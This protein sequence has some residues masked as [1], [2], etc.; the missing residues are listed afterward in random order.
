MTASSQKDGV[1]SRARFSVPATVSKIASEQLGA[2][3]KML[4]SLPAQNSPTN[5]KEWQERQSLVEAI[6]RPRAASTAEQL[7]VSLDE[8]SI[9]GVNILRISPATKDTAGR[10][11]IFL[12]GGGYVLF[13]AHSNL[14]IPALIA[15]ATGCEV[16]SVDYTLAP[17][18]NWQ[19]ITDQILSVWEG[20]VES[21]IKP[22]A[23]GLFGDSAGGALAAG[24]V[25]KMRDRGLQL[26]GALYLVS[27]WSDITVNGDTIQTLESS[28]P[29]LKPEELLACANVYADPA[30]QHHPYVSP[31]NGDYSKP[32]PPTLIQAGTREIFL[33]H[34]VRHY[35]AI[36][37]GGNKCLLDIYEGMPHAFPAIVPFAPEA[38]TAINRAARFLLEE[39]S[40]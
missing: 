25:L 12:H 13:S 4:E 35:N 31:I 8:D 39:L 33:S 19:T 27:P 2:F 24:A 10:K 7:N 15:D 40:V 22:E 26:P 32:F 37:D 38:K 28:D 34:A 17:E 14:A 6:F 11:L 29:M 20:L 30:D 5:Q 3:Y 23:T 16:I 36:I 18:G 1:L 9:G 21:G